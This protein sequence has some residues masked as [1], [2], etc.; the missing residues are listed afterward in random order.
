MTLGGTSDLDPR[1]TIGLTA[2]NVIITNDDSMFYSTT[3]RFSRY[4]PSAVTVHIEY[5]A[6]SVSEGEGVVEVC[7]VIQST[8][9]RSADY[10]VNNYAF[11]VTV[12]SSDDTTGN[13]ISVV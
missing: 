6:Y 12:A 7:D 2:G 11:E 4:I 3:Y 1:I 13:F 9:N 5:P 8:S 10:P